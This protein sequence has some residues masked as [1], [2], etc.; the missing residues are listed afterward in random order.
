M[1]TQSQVEHRSCIHAVVEVLH[2]HTVTSRTKVMYSCS[3]GG[4][5]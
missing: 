1:N 5:T 4:T 3:S 2:E